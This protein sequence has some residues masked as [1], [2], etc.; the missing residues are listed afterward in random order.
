MS[1]ALRRKFEE[2]VQG[3]LCQG[4]GRTQLCATRR[5]GQVDSDRQWQSKPPGATPA[6]LPRPL[7]VSAAPYRGLV[8]FPFVLASGVKREVV[9][10]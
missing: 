3:Q 1:S 7:H 2:V 10:C 4:E 8:G 6:S 5:S 9:R